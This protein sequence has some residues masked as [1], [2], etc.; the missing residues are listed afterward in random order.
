MLTLCRVEAFFAYHMHAT[1]L[2]HA[3]TFM[4]SL[5]LLPTDS[6]FPHPSVLHAMCAVGSLYTAAVPDSQIFVE[7]IETPCTCD[8]PTLFFLSILQ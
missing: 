5:D 8:S 4:A 6:R 7:P 2:F 1:R 3:A